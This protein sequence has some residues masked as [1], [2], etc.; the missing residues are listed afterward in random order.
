[1]AAVVSKELTVTDGSV[2]AAYSAEQIEVIRNHVATP[3]FTDTELV[4]CL[5]TARARGLDPLQKQVYFT[6]RKKKDGH[7]GY[8][9]SVTVE[10]TIDGYRA[11]AE[12]TGELQGYEGPFWCGADGE[13]KDAWLSRTPP[14][15]AKIVVHRKGKE[16]GFSAVARYDAYVQTSFDGKPNHMWQKMADN[17]LAKCAEALALRKA[18]PSQLGA[19]YTREEMGQA[20]EPETPARPQSRWAQ[21]Q[22]EATPV[23]NVLRL[24][25][26]ERLQNPIEDK[27]TLVR[28]AM[29]IS[30]FGE[31]GVSRAAIE[32]RIG[33]SLD[34][35]TDKDILDLT[36]V[37]RVIS[38]A[39][40]TV[41]QH[42]PGAR[43]P[44]QTR[45]ERINSRYKAKQPPTESDSH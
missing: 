45:A 9:T 27:Q 22:D 13:W 21:L 44:A 15:A 35:C 7:G 24:P 32:A 12:R 20:D 39:P 19:L 36:D 18:F 43:A 2:M 31:M 40:Q 33:H 1:M 11:M 25:E 17:Q 6:K 16:Y 29:M 38:K 28:V 10:P 42:F 3:D 41:G 8:T 23:E 4:Y 5:A 14:V 37:Y 34:Q 30:K 26:G